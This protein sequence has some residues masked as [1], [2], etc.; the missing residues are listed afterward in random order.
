ME[1]LEIKELYPKNFSLKNCN[2]NEKF[3]K[4]RELI[5]LLRQKQLPDYII[6]FINNEIESINNLSIDEDLFIK[7]FKSSEKRI[8]IFLEREL[9]IVPKNYYRNYYLVL[10]ISIFGVPIGVVF[11]A[12][13]GNMGLLGIGI[14]IGL[15]IGTS[16]GTYLDKK[17]LLE[18]RQLNI[19][20]SIL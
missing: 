20:I 17:A 9:K 15:G 1:Q 5:N 16:I 13:I 11:G 7:K 19:E 14:P 6:E 4:F 3:V 8:I 18:N 10:G 12:I 2:A